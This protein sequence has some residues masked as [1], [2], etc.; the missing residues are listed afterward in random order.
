MTG[1]RTIEAAE[2][3]L[4]LGLGDAAAD[5]PEVP[6]VDRWH[7]IVQ[8]V[9]LTCTEA[10][11]RELCQRHGVTYPARPAPPTKAQREAA[12]EAARRAALPPLT[13]TQRLK[14]AERVVRRRMEAAK[15]CT[16]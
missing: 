9:A 1:I 14:I 3:E 7:D 2:R 16:R 13:P 11:G 6:E 5:F 8:A 12:A 10:V 15:G 4:E